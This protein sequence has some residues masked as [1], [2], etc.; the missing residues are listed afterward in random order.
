MSLTLKRESLSQIS[1]FVIIV[2]C[3]LDFISFF[4]VFRE[5]TLGKVIVLGL[6]LFIVFYWLIIFIREFVNS[7]YFLVHKRALILF[8]I[9]ISMLASYG[10]QLLLGYDSQDKL[11]SS[12]L[13][14]I[15][16]IILFSISWLVIGYSVNSL[17]LKVR[18]LAVTIF[19]LALFVV[20]LSIDSFPFVSYE[21]LS[22]KHGL[23][24]EMSLSHLG[25]TD[26][27]IIL[28][29]V[30]FASREKTNFICIFIALF[31]LLSLGGRSALF[32]FIVSTAIV[33][34]I[35][36]SSRSKTIMI[37]ASFTF[38]VPAVGL[39]MSYI[40]LSDNKTM[41]RFF[42][43]N[44]LTGDGSLIQR[45]EQFRIS[46]DL[47]PEQLAVGNYALNVEQT[48]EFGG[49]IHNILSAWQFYGVVI[50]LVIL[51]TS[52]Q[53]LYSSINKYNFVKYDGLYNASWLYIYACLSLL[54]S[55]YIG[56][57][58]FW[59]ALGYLANCL[60]RNY[61]FVKYEKI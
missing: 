15:G 28:T 38:L 10:I 43:A 45:L 23:S 47:L 7:K 12:T 40:D 14:R 17:S 25:I 34:F 29:M 55:K 61:V 6:S 56:F 13:G 49:Y 31:M 3:L 33:S 53:Y 16:Y 26:S 39:F 52:L 27:A 60:R 4:V 9:I 20:C 24:P 30:F 2:Y 19:L 57:Y 48:K 51:S 8:I 42:F 1:L 46:I 18:Y 11:G 5:N 21:L 22:K 58:L 35:K 54:L 37:I 41:A 59:F 44:G 36:A 50:F 32:L